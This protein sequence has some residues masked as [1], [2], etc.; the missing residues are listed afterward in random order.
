ML[1]LNV[2]NARWL[3]V[4]VPIEVMLP[5]IEKTIGDDL[6]ARKIAVEG[7]VLNVASRP[8][9]PIFP[10]WEARAALFRQAAEKVAPS[11]VAIKVNRTA[12]DPRFTA[13]IPVGR[14]GG[15]AQF[16]EELF[17]RPEGA[18]VT[19]VI[20]DSGGW[21]ATSY[22]NVA[23]T[24]KSVS[25]VLPGGKEVKAEVV[26]WD[27]ERDLALLKVKAEGLPAVEFGSDAKLGAYVCVLGRS[28]TPDSL[29]LTSGI[30]SAVGRGEDSLLQFDAK[31]NV[32]NT[33]GP[34]IGLDGKCLG[35]VCGVSTNSQ[36]GQNSGIAFAAW[37]RILPQAIADMKGGSK[38]RHR[39]RPTLGIV[40][41]PGAVD[42]PG[43]L[44]ARVL[45]E[46][47]AEKAGI[48]RNDSIL[49]ID[50]VSLDDAADL[51]NLVRDKQPGD[52]VKLL[53][54]R[55]ARE[56]EIEATLEVRE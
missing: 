54:R 47:P 30:I 39:P 4:A 51:V 27:Q 33:G 1:S 23:G 15:P 45:P 19:G 2:S 29:T 53:V 8:G 14:T 40:V 48:Q 35:I 44:V 28:P 55:R 34:L 21:I 7:P 52:K 5:D 38:I 32:G 13:R 43:V 56:M 9:A 37:S 36:H 49:K 16:L 26:G 22:F 6:A 12:D 17:K 46:S 24:L 20:V 18:T 42:I 10:R 11:V 3:G 50:G 25:V 41:A 31:V